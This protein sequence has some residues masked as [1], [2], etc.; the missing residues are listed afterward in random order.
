M[1]LR[2]PLWNPTLRKI[3]ARKWLHPGDERKGPRGVFGE[4]IYIRISWIYFFLSESRRRMVI[5]Q[6]SLKI[7]VPY[8][9]SSASSDEEAEQVITKQH[10]WFHF[11]F[12]LIRV[13]SQLWCCHPKCFHP[14]SMHCRQCLQP[15]ITNNR[16]VCRLF[17]HHQWQC[18]PYH[19]PFK[20]QAQTLVIQ[21]PHR[22][23]DGM[24][25]HQPRTARKQSADLQLK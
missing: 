3:K 7:E 15:I 16:L 14:K 1:G 12:W 11:N 21:G 17:S 9:G 5:T 8:A 6:G 18:S 13:T 4:L 22:F 20:W 24:G 10:Y 25:T 23:G 2:R 19:K